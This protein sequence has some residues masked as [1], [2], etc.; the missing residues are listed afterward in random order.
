MQRYIKI[1]ND[2]ALFLDRDG[3][4]NI[5]SEGGYVLQPADFEFID[6]SCQAIV[7]L[8]R[9]FCHTFIVT[10]QSCI[11][12][13]L[14]S[15]TRRPDIHNPLQPSVADAGG[16]IGAI[17]HSPYLPESN[18]FMRKPNIGMAL[19]ARRDYP[20]INLKHSIMVGDSLT[21][22]L[23]AKRAGMI[24]VLVGSCSGIANQHPQLVDFY[25]RNLA[26]FAELAPF[27]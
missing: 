3:V 7:T 19:R 23:F 27:L 26:E 25:F 2:S 15:E 11:G 24:A 16:C 8:S 1:H 12:K 21:D 14:M 4:I 9:I 13:R 5:R 22:M 17:Y 18:H 10:N 20:D 6:G